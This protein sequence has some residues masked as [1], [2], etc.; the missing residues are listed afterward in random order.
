MKLML[1]LQLELS[2]GYYL[3]KGR[4]WNM[5]K[6]WN[7][8]NLHHCLKGLEFSLHVDASQKGLEF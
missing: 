3:Q 7:L 8:V 4:I 6:G 1:C 5:F 2:K